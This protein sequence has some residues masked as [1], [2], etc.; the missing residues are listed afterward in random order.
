MRGLSSF[1][2][3]S[4]SVTSL[5]YSH[6]LALALLP[7][8]RP[9][10]PSRS[11]TCLPVEPNPAPR[12]RVQEAIVTP[13]RHQSPPRRFN[14]ATRERASPCTPRTTFFPIRFFCLLLFTF[15]CTRMERGSGRR[16]RREIAKDHTIVAL[17]FPFALFSRC[18]ILSPRILLYQFILLIHVYQ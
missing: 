12:S 5:P 15:R 16:N 6:A 2:R 3:P 10:S 14:S 17:E 11:R 8:S 7:P 13:K 9:P 1:L 18:Y 4:V